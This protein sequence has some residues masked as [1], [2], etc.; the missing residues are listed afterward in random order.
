MLAT[1]ALDPFN[2]ADHLFEIKWDGT[3]CLT[4]RDA[5]G[6]RLR[7]RRDFEMLAR[8][9]ELQILDALPD[10]TLLD[11][12]IIAL[13]NG[14]PSFQKIMQRDHARDPNRIATL[15]RTLPVTYMVFDLLYDSGRS[16]M[17]EVLPERQ[18]RLA[19]VVAALGSEHVVLTDHVVENGR[20]YFE[21]AA[22]M[23][24]EGIMAKR[25]ASTY[26]P[27][28]RSDDWVKIK[29]AKTEEFDIIGYSAKNAAGPMSALLLGTVAEGRRVFMGKVGTGFTDEQ[30]R[31]FFELLVNADPMPDPPSGGPADAVW[32]QCRWRC[33]VRYFER[34]AGGMLRGPVFLDLLE[35]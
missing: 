12:E 14:R 22:R 8:Y 33:R 1:S 7:N 2:S 19:G 15:V 31:G 17:R 11:G 3:R 32:R 34:T 21:A 29:V 28:R 26:T 24:L 13:D 9:P 10:G 5:Q 20:S 18:A 6:L 30:R 16:M 23:G 25:M 27:N 35:S 4:F